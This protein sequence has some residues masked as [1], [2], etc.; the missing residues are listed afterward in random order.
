MPSEYEYPLSWWRLGDSID[1]VALGGEVV[2]EYAIGLKEILGS[3]TWV[4]GYSHDVMAYIPSRR[5]WNEGG[6]EGATSMIYYG[7]PDRW[8]EDVEQRVMGAIRQLID[9]Q[10]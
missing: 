4:A 6:Y 5:I 3:D 10:P 9:A 7:Q 1:W 8:G 2:V